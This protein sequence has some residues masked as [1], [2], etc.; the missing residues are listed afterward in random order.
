VGATGAVFTGPTGSTGSTGTTG[1]TG[2]TGPTGSTGA[3][4]ATGS[5]GV[6]GPTG[7]TG[8]TGSTGVTGPT[9]ATG[10]TG[11]TGATGAT[12]SV[13]PL[14]SLLYVDQLAAPGGDGSIAA[15]FTTI[16]AANAAFLAKG[17]PN[18]NNKYGIF[19]VP[20]IYPENVN[21]Y[22]W[23]FLVGT[24]P[25]TTR[26][27]GTLALWT[28]PGNADNYW[29]PPDNPDDN[30]TDMRG[31]LINVLVTNALTIDFNVG[32]TPGSSF[33]GSNEGKF[34]LENCILN[35]LFTMVGFSLISQ[36]QGRGCQFFS[37]YTI[38]GANWQTENSNVTG[39]A[40][41][42]LTDAN[43]PAIL[44]CFGGG[45][46][47]PLVATNTVRGITVSLFGFAVDGPLT[48]SSSGSLT[49]AATVEGF[50][51]VQTLT[52]NPTV[53]LITL[54]NGLAYSPQTP[55]NWSPVPTQVAQ[56]LDELAARPS[57][58]ATGATGATGSTGA[59]GPTGSTGATGAG[60]TG[61]TGPTGSTGATG[62]T[63]PT[64]STGST[65][66]TGTTGPTG[67][68]GAT[69]ATGATGSGAA[70]VQTV[71]AN[72][73]QGGISSGTGQ[74]ATLTLTAITSTPGAPGNFEVGG[75]A[76]VSTSAAGDQVQATLLKNGSPIGPTVSFRT[77]TSAEYALA[78]GPFVDTPG[79][80]TYAYAIQIT[81]TTAGHT[82]QFNSGNVVAQESF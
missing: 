6:T 41:I 62:A 4:G 8:P 48:L 45:T 39:G 58:G 22:P 37:G 71:L 12:P 68:G 34:Y 75:Y 31:G 38:N 19:L 46:N 16:A 17:V 72:R 61:G 42:T 55:G 65:G 82:V 14:S 32:A 64:G 70:L 63:G 5:T 78:I 23:I 27:T 67:S 66:P 51:L 47:G 21:L 20:G 44:T 57:S 9:G 76:S 50:P 13:P 10:P 33:T 25:F 24:D 1:A 15:P 36:G 69:G 7:A 40:A 28:D 74:S 3:T 49:Y 54:A 2:S 53:T 18:K 29:N 43:I 35:S 59:T 80:G 30:F 81:N 26:L 77:D 56:A 11:S 73:Q 60:S 52:G 79:P